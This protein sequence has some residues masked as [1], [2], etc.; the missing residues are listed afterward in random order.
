MMIL[1]HKT[2]LLCLGL[3][4]A[5]RSW[6]TKRTVD[7]YTV[8][9]LLWSDGEWQGLALDLITSLVRLTYLQVETTVG[10]GTYLYSIDRGAKTAHAPLG[11][12]TDPDHCVCPS[13]VMGWGM[14]QCVCVWIHYP[15]H[16]VMTS[17]LLVARCCLNDT[18]WISLS[19]VNGFVDPFAP[20]GNNPTAFEKGGSIVRGYVI[21]G[22]D[23]VA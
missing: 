17:F 9:S 23:F 6:L 5:S 19:K 11:M 13:V 12:K 20:T 2:S 15:L 14:N 18:N 16:R 10:N 7:L 1:D 4:Q 22:T 21:Q 3:Q 8:G